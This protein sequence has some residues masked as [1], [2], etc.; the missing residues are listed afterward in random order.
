MFGFVRPT[1]CLVEWTALGLL[2]DPERQEGRH[3]VGTGCA[4]AR[5]AWSAT[6]TARRPLCRLLRGVAR[7]LHLGQQRPRGWRNGIG[8]RASPT[9][10]RRRRVLPGLSV[11]RRSGSA[12]VPSDGS[13][14]TEVNGKCLPATAQAARLTRAEEPGGLS[15]ATRGP[16]HDSILREMAI[17][18]SITAH[19]SASSPV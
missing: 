17:I 1:R 7:R 14:P 18:R 13:A 9:R 15:A 3:G 8:E 11:Q 4:V 16:D 12:T 6:G 2:V 10:E 19:L 5:V